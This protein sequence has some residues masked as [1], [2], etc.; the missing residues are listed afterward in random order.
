MAPHSTSWKNWHSFAHACERSCDP[1]D[2][3]ALI[4]VLR[5]EMFGISDEALYQ[6]KR[7]GGRFS[8]REPIM[9]TG[10]PQV[11]DKP[12]RDSLGRLNRYFG[13]LDVLP[14]VA[15]IERIADDL[16][17]VAQACTPPA[18]TSAGSLA[19]V[20]ELCRAVGSEQLSMVELVDFLE[21]LVTA[22]EKY[23][24]ISV[25]PHAAPVVRLMNLHKVK[26]LE[27]PVVILADPT[28]DHKHPID[29]HIDRSGDC[30]RGYMG[31]Y[32]PR[33]ETGYSPPRVIA[34]HSDWP[35]FE[36]TE[37]KFLDAEDDRLLY[38]AATR[39][40]ACLV[41]SHREKRVNENPWRTLTKDLVGRDIYE[42]PG[43]QSA[44]AR[45][46]VSVK[47][48]DVEAGVKEIDERWTAVR[49]PTYKVEALKAAAMYRDRKEGD[50]HRFADSWSDSEFEVGAGRHFGGRRARCRMGRRHTRFAGDG[51]AAARRG[52]V[53]PRAP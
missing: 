11:H 25:R 20:F 43:P 3:V 7:A 33:P 41:I 18:P 19:K 49:R 52:F 12:I 27:A 36:D 29:F 23:D 38:V 40:G 15:S 5:S 46:K 10:L 39:A 53:E 30:V 9:A 24:G 26:G 2:P 17:L 35:R 50:A 51:D 42:D 48:A 22:D 37:R 16:G 34:C 14:A 21:R 44:P 1:D 6:Y 13:W 8:F 32:A 4:A 31:V 28:G 45:K 47:V